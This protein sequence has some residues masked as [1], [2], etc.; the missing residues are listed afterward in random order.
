[1]AARASTS[2][3]SASTRGRWLKAEAKRLARKERRNRRALARDRRLQR[4][5]QRIDS[6]AGGHARRLRDGQQRIENGDARGRLRIEARHLLM[7]L[8]IRDQRGALALA[9]GAR[10]RRDGDERE[11]RLRRL[12]HA[13][14]VL[15]LAA[16]GEEKVAPL[17]G[18]HGGAAAEADEQIDA[19]PRAPPPR[20]D[21]RRRWSG[22]RAPAEYT[23]TSRPAAAMKPDRAPRVPGAHDP[24][25]RHEQRAPRAELARQHAHL[26]QRYPARR[27]AGCAAGNR[28]SEAREP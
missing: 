17:R 12:A 3:G 7:R 15:H 25:I 23:S 8:L 27:S 24:L 18:I 5:R 22:F 10:G 1:M 4:V 26:L 2:P 19:A 9:A 28:R 14:V 13:P 20:S 11:H 21:P 6:R 16:I